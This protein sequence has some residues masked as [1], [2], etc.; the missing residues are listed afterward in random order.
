MKNVSAILLLVATLGSTGCSALGKSPSID[1]ALL[2]ELPESSM[3]SIVEAR[4]AKDTFEDTYAKAK[5]DTKWSAEQVELSRSS[6]NVLRSELEDAKLAIV[7]SDRSGTTSQLASAQAAHEYAL[8]RAD[9]GRE[10][11]SL[12]KREFEAAK[13]TEKV[14]LEE[15]RLSRARVELEKAQAVQTLDRVAAKRIAVKDFVKQVRYHETEVELARVHLKSAE[16]EVQDAK[17]VYESA[18]K[19]AE[20]KKVDA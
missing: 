9:V 6:L 7:L 14:A 2:S 18:V 16:T 10:L 17:S 11:L 1:S 15:L 19:Q 13:L 20:A 12:R 4:A 3:V 8:A 5:R